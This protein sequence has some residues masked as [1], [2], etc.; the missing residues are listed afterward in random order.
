MPEGGTTDNPVA[1]I[2][3]EPVGDIGPTAR[4]QFNIDRPSGIDREALVE[5][6]PTQSLDVETV[7][8]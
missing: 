1:L 5:H 3:M 4:E 6:P 8:C 2:L 7:G